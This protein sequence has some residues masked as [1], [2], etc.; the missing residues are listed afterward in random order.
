MLKDEAPVSMLRMSVT[1]L[2]T[3]DEISELKEKEQLQNILSIDAT[4]SI[5][6]EDRLE[7][8]KWTL[9]NMPQNMRLN[10]C[11]KVFMQQK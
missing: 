7:L 3:H 11:T 8:K 4:W 10:L 2:T 6:Y 9:L 1:S 5:T